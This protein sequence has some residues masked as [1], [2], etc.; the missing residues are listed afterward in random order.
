MKKIAILFSVFC[1]FSVQ[2]QTQQGNGVY[3]LLIGIIIMM[4]IVSI[5][6]M[7]KELVLNKN[8]SETPNKRIM[9]DVFID[10]DKANGKM[11]N[12]YK[13][14]VLGYYYP[15]K[16]PNFFEDQKVFSGTETECGRWLMR[17][18]NKQPDF[19]K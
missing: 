1:A 5:P 8:N 18:Q 9:H 4:V 7:I 6:A 14:K 2:A 10:S 3:D 11:L 16:T 15:A 12:I 17:N 19:M 13:S